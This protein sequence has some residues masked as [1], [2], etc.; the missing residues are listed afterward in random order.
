MKNGWYLDFLKNVVYNFLDKVNNK[1][2]TFYYF[3]NDLLSKNLLK[4]KPKPT[5]ATIVKYL[6]NY[7]KDIL[8]F[9]TDR[10][11]YLNRKSRKLYYE[12]YNMQYGSFLWSIL[13]YEEHFEILFYTGSTSNSYLYAPYKLFIPKFSEKD[14]SAITEVVR[15][16]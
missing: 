11:N 10:D 13:E 1:E 2:T 12:L 5:E 15:N 4:V 16:V 8:E 14:I 7:L 6:K 3:V 9:Y